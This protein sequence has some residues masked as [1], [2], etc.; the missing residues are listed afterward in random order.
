[1]ICVFDID[2]TLALC[3]HRLH[4]IKNKPSNWRAF[5]AAIPF[6]EPNKPIISLFHSLL[7]SPGTE[8]VL[9]SGRNE[10]CRKETMDWLSTHLLENFDLPLYMRSSKDYRSDDIVKVEIL[11]EIKKIHGTPR[12]WFDDRPRVVKAIRDQGIFVVDVNQSGEDF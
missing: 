10:D 5:F 6:D 3:E 9:A 1:M 11:Q 12:I 7:V 2:G 4:W 8:I